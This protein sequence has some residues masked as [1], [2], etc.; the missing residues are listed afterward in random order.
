MG[1]GFV[2]AAGQVQI[3]DGGVVDHPEGVHALG[4]QVH[5]ALARSGGNEEQM[6]FG[7][8]GLEIVVEALEELGHGY[9]P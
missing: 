8:E 9:F 6:L 2:T 5:P 1:R 3:A 4:R 7:D